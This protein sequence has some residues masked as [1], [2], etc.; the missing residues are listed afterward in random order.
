MIIFGKQ[1]AIRRATSRRPEQVLGRY[2]GF[3]SRAIALILDQA[4]IGI[5]VVAL[6][7]IVRSILSIG[8]M[9]IDECT[10]WVRPIQS[11]SDVFDNIC[12]ATRGGTFIASVLLDPLYYI[13]L[14][15]FGG[16]TLGM[17][18]TG[19]RVVRAD[20]TP[21]PLARAILRMIGFVLCILSLGFGFLRVN[22]DDRRQGWHD[23]LANS[24]VVYS[25][26][27]TTTPA[28]KSPLAPI[29]V[30]D[31]LPAKS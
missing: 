29:P 15:T 20:G 7:L 4:I 11:V 13:I 25:W 1:G 5:M 8:G 6:F 2:A 23:K 28:Q 24:Y 26:K 18:V 22:W 14:W 21:I 3:V 9:H 10:T 27:H 30:V 16:Q 31:D 19:V 12:R 17:S